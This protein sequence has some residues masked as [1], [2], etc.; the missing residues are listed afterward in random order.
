ME[1]KN[2]YQLVIDVESFMTVLLAQ[3]S[4][5]ALSAVSVIFV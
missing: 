3:P 4:L 5:K 2:N 1:K